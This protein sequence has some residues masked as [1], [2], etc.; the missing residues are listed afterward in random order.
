LKINP[1]QNLNIKDQATSNQSTHSVHTK[2]NGNSPKI[3]DKGKRNLTEARPEIGSGSPEN[4]PE[5]RS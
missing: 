2:P 3:K 5:K 1:N 4:S